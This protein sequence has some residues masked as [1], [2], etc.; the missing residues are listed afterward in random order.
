MK[1]KLI[2]G[3]SDV[4]DFPGLGLAG[5]PVKVDT[6]AYTSSIHCSAISVDESGEA[7]VL[8][9]TLLDD[10]HDAYH[11]RQLHTAEFSEKLVKNSFGTSERR[12]VVKTSIA[13]FGKR[14]RISLSLSERGE[15]RFPVLLG[16]KFLKNK[17]LVDPAA[18]D[19]SHAATEGPTASGTPT[20]PPA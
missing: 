3:R 19:L 7:P 15:M 14:Y 2:I 6:G 8:R 12:Y 17:F 1:H 18:T 4:A 11:G 16:R 5:I 13:L 9:F 20:D 10:S